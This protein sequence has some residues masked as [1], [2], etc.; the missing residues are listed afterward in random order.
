MPSREDL[1]GIVHSYRKY[2]PVNIPP[3]IG[4]AHV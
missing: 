1:G 3:Q 4:R 2:D